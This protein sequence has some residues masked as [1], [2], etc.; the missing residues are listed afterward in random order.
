MID[1]QSAS[2]L[3]Q[4]GEFGPRIHIPRNVLAFFLFV[5]SYG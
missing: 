4:P 5:A 3:R 2:L 1:G